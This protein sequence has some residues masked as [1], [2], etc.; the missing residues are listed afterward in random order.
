[1]SGWVE[2]GQRGR[3]ELRDEWDARIAKSRPAKPSPPSSFYP[4]AFGGE[5]AW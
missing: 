1:M 3:G 2:G 4:C 5:T